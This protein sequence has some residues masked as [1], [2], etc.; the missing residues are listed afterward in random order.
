MILAR[1]PYFET[2]HVVK[3]GFTDKTLVFKDIGKTTVK[4]QHYICKRCIKT[5]QTDLTNLV[6]KN[7]NLRTN[8]KVNLNI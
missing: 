6:D 1:Y 2:L 4:V 7:S 3:Y 8:W 5:I